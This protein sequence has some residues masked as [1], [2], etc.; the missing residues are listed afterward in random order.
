M[1]QKTDLKLSSGIGRN[2]LYNDLA[3]L[4]PI[5]SPHDHYE[6]EARS[7][8]DKFEEFSTIPIR[9]LLE[10]GCG[11]GHNAYFLKNHYTLTCVDLSDAMLHNAQILNPE[12]RHLQ[13]DM[14]SFQLSERFDAVLI[15]DAINYILTE[16]D[17][18]ATFQ[19]AFRHLNPGGIFI[20]FIEQY[21]ERILNWSPGHHT[22]SRGD[23]KVIYD[24]YNFDVDPTDTIL[25]SLI[26]YRIFI[27]NELRVES[28]LH[29]CGVFPFNTWTTLL[30]HCGFE[31]TVVEIK[32]PTFP[33]KATIPW[34]VSV[35]P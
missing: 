21:K 18:L 16:S 30:N 20:T 11:G 3:W 33:G 7:L 23:V 8:H 24:E 17:L 35:R 19:T 22:L 32:H 26:I 13:G 5:M 9:T 29:T 25:E 15:H 1:S 34:L 4:W 31:V 27:N 12:I 28:D 2:R 14:R 6:E 10:L